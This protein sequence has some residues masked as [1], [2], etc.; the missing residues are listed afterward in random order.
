MVRQNVPGRDPYDHANVP[1][2]LVEGRTLTDR[3][4]WTLHTDSMTRGHVLEQPPHSPLSPK[5]PV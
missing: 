4:A 5:V 2:V 3:R 1:H